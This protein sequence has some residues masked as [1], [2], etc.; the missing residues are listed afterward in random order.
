MARKWAENSHLCI[1]FYWHD[2]T[3]LVTFIDLKTTGM[4]HLKFNYLI[5][6]FYFKETPNKLRA[7]SLKFKI[8]GFWDMVPCTLE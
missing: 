6:T 7:L 8:P 4:C 5:L 2:G 3:P 1:K